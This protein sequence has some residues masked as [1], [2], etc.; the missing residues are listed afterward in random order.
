MRVTE[1]PDHRTGDPEPSGHVPQIDPATAD[2]AGASAATA[3]G[4]ATA[5]A[6]PASAE[7]L[8]TLF[9]GDDDAA[10][11][12]RSTP[13]GDTALGDPRTWSPDL[14]AAV[15]TVMPSK[16]PML[17]WW[18]EELVQIYNDAYRGLVGSKHPAAMGQRGDECWAEVWGDLGPMTAQVRE[19]GEANFERDLLL[20]MDR[21]GY[22][23]ETYWTFSFSP[24]R[25]A[26]GDVVGVFVATT[27]VT[28]AVVEARR[29]DIVRDLA[30]LSSADFSSREGIAEAVTQVLAK[31]R[32]A[33]PFA[34][35]YLPDGAGGL[36]Q[37]ARYGLSGPSPELPDAVSAARREHP[38]VEVART[39]KRSE[40]TYDP[41][42]LGAG[43]GPLGPLPPSSAFVLPLGGTGR[44]LEGVVVLGINPY[45]RV[46]E[47]YVTYS[48][49]VTRQLTALFVE[50]RAATEERARTAALAELDR[51][52][53]EFFANVS[54]EFRTPLTV[55]LA[56]LGELRASGLSGKQAQHVDAVQRSAE[57][58]NR[59]VDTL[60][61]FA[62][63]EGG[64]LTPVRE[65]VDVT[66][67]TVDVVGMFRSTIES[68]GLGLETDVDEVGGR[69]LDR[70]AWVK[71]VANLL[72]NAYKFTESGSIR[73]SLR[74]SDKEVVLTIQD[75]GRGI[76]PHDVDR[77]FE[78]FHQVVRQPARGVAGTGIGLA[79]VK[80]LVAAHGGSVT[81]E[82]AVGTGSTF[83]VT[84]PAIATELDDSTPRELRTLVDVLL[85][86]SEESEDEPVAPEQSDQP[87]LL[88]V[89]DNADLRRY[90]TRLLTDDSWNVVAVPDVAGALQL[91][92]VPDLI[93]SDVMLP[94]A[95]GLDLVR[96]VRATPDW[97]SVPVILLTARSGPKE[98]ASGLSVGADDYVGKPFEPTELLARLRTHYELAQG[99]GRLIAQAQEKAGHLQTALSTNRTI[100][101]AVGVVMSSYRLPSDRAFD[102]LR[103]HSNNTNR[104]LRDVAEEV[105]LTGELPLG[106]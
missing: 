68:A 106:D 75:T 20:F 61:N 42:V 56:A 36:V 63:A 47:R 37:A 54:H 86:E 69:L 27:D 35:V 5:G 104:K 34:V 101:M 46:D 4:A 79:L 15:R 57:R 81:L 39:R 88:L 62:R 8:A 71:V 102:L 74:S 14:A 96:T 23:E 91:D 12:A 29:L 72:S 51:S 82:S 9:P 48:T 43:P 90:L 76:D 2:A 22:L 33:V 53:S 64:H 41:A 73:V 25:S 89:E 10:V 1:F 11:L 30:V 49:L 7:L 67:L 77:V 105:V 40:V 84:L 17:L 78:R 59:L 83:T 85:A 16:V 26:Q 21:H 70:E 94:G 99:R 19:S 13:W 55:A 66:E 52:K 6:D 92:R 97:A 50:V 18:G 24:I 98:V 80:D 60:L 103:V 93:L 38:L 28:L 87:V 100:G 32:H 45:R 58:L 31:N 95:S 3:A 44:P 65:P